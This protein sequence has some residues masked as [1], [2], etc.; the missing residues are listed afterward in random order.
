MET[1][2]CKGCKESKPL[3]EYHV[4]NGKTGVL[5]VRCKQCAAKYAREYRQKNRD[6]VGRYKMSK[7][8][9][10]CGFQ[11]EHSCQLDLHHI[12][13]EEKTYKG[14]HKSYDAGWSKERIDREIA[15]CLVVCKN[16]HALESHK[17][18]HW[19]NPTTCIDMR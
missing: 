17:L 7:G 10:I 1:K 2:V 15:R 12:N 18:G 3:S 4:S 19:K 5:H 16:C 14:S 6:Y 9:E 11:P 13:P 8:C